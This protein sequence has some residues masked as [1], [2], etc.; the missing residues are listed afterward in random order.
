MHEPRRYEEQPK[1]VFGGVLSDEAYANAITSFIIVCTDIVS[2]DREK[3]VFHLA[4]RIV[5]SAKGIWR[6]GGR[7]RAG[8]TMR[9]SC[10]RL[11]EKELG[12]TL[13]PERFSYV[14]STDE[15]FSYRKLPP[16]EAGSHSLIHIFT[17]ELT[18]LERETAVVHLDPNEYDIEFGIQEFDRA[19]LVEEGVYSQLIDLYDTVFPHA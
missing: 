9:E 16:Q 13:T 6:F 15:L 7:Q 17:V 8:E 4:K 5:H 12:L 1:R 19:R 14:Q 2:I 11:M 3:K 18:P 10:V